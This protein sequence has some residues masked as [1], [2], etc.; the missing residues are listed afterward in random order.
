MS[1]RLSLSIAVAL[2]FSATAGGGARANPIPT[3]TD[4]AR[5]LAGR[6][7]SSQHIDATGLANGPVT[8][9]DEARVRAGRSL[10]ASPGA[11]VEETIARNTDEGRAATAAGHQKQ[12]EKQSVAASLPVTG[13]ADPGN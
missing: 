8:S 5:A 4:E 3:S 12:T 11:W 10:P 9:T 2:A 13:T 6:V 7:T 1:S